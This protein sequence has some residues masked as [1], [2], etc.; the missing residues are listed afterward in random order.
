MSFTRILG[1]GDVEIEVPDG[2]TVR[3][4][5]S[6]MVETW[7]QSLSSHLFKPGTEELLPH[8]VLMV[9]GRIIHFLE[10][11]ETELRTDDLVLLF[12]PA[13]GG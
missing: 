4:L 11:M 13:A 3:D 2:A 7:G 6:K 5:L 10:G 9:N 12:P 8:V 1:S